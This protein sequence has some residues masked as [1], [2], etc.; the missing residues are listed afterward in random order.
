M[1]ITQNER[2]INT[3]EHMN[4]KARIQYHAGDLR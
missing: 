4:I 3:E 1:L 2:S